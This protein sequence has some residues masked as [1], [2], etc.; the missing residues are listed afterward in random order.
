MRV[1]GDEESTIYEIEV[2]PSIKIYVLDK[3]TDYI[4]VGTDLIKIDETD[5]K[6]NYYL[7][8]K[9]KVNNTVEK[10]NLYSGL[11]DYTEYTVKVEIEGIDEDEIVEKTKAPN[12]SII[13]FI[14]EKVKET[15]VYSAAY[16]GVT[17]NFDVLY[18]DESNIGDYGTYDRGSN[19]YTIDKSIAVGDATQ[20]RMA[21]LKCPGNLII[22]DGVEIGA[23]K[24]TTTETQ[25]LRKENY[26]C[27]SPNNKNKRTICIL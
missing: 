3:G 22:S 14:G 20:Y 25:T 19:T 17:Y 15:K 6:Y 5:L 11:T 9:K 10:T 7:N 27:N 12:D 13:G 26:R 18:I 24:Y 8:G 23:S 21:V 2:I 16:G 4:R 1:S